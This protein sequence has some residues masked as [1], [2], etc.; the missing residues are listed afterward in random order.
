MITL[1]D[2]RRFTPRWTSELFASFVGPRLLLLAGGLITAASLAWLCALTGVAL[3]GETGKAL[4]NREAILRDGF[5]QDGQNVNLLPITEGKPTNVIEARFAPKVGDVVY[6]IPK[7]GRIERGNGSVTKKGWKPS[8]S[9]ALVI[10]EETQDL[11]QLHLAATKS[12]LDQSPNVV[13]APKSGRLDLEAMLKQWRKATG[14]RTPI[15]V[16]RHAQHPR[17]VRGDGGAVGQARRADAGGVPAREGPVVG[18]ARRL[19]GTLD[20]RERHA[21][22]DALPAGR[23]ASPTPLSTTCAAIRS[24]TSCA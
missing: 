3:V 21:R 20:R 1:S 9:E 22:A 17:R 8:P 2:S 5:D 14:D 23:S 7:E 10:T 19:E 11:Y 6:L 4:E 24:V 16:R 12:E 13:T 15:G 18:Q